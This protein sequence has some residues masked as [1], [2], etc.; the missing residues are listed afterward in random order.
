MYFLELQKRLVGMAR[1]RVRAGLN[2]ERGLARESGLSQPHMHNVLKNIR[3]LSVRSADQMLRGLK[4]TI[5]DLLWLPVDGAGSETRSVPVLRTPVGPGRQASFEVHRAHMPLPVELL[6][7]LVDPVLARLAPD[8][9]LPAA[10]VPGDLVLLDQNPDLRNTPRGKTYWVIADGG[11]L[12]VR[13][14]RA[15]GAPL[16]AAEAIRAR[17]VWLARELEPSELP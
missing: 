8:L 3:A 15:E 13:L 11:G 12:R 14:L 16:T 10:F 7:G 4:L 5:P 1:Q 2:T 17:V 9:L 6:R